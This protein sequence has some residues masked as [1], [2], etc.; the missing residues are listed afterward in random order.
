MFLSKDWYKLCPQGKWKCTNTYLTNPGRVKD[1]SF[2][3]PKVSSHAFF[4]PYKDHFRQRRARAKG[5]CGSS[6]NDTRSQT[7]D[8]E[9]KA[10]SSHVSPKQ[11]TVKIIK[12]KTPLKFDPEPCVWGWRCS[13]YEVAR[14]GLCNHSIFG[15]K[16]INFCARCPRLLRYLT[17]FSGR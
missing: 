11:S 15:K 7:K 3:W 4:R 14:Y 16:C 5:Q 17:Y 13:P 12:V 10:S 1:G 6:E 8:E 2:R 9:D